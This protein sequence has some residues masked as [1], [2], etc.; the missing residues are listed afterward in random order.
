MLLLYTSVSIN[1][2]IDNYSSVSCWWVMLDMYTADA[3]VYFSKL[4]IFTSGLP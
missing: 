3:A 2:D 1:F 4:T